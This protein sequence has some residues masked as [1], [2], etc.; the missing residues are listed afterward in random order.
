MKDG[1]YA[2]IF[3]GPWGEVYDE[4]EESKLT[5]DESRAEELLGYKPKVDDVA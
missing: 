1:I 2:Y 3:G 4:R 5:D